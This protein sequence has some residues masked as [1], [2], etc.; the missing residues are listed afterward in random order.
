MFVYVMLSYDT[1]I[2]MKVVSARLALSAEAINSNRQKS[3]GF[4]LI[5]LLVVLSIVGLLSTII[6]VALQGARGK[7]KIASGQEFANNVYH[8]LGTSVVG[9]WNFDEGAGT[10]STDQSGNGNTA[11]G[12]PSGS[13]VTGLNGRAISLLSGQSVT[14]GATGAYS[15]PSFTIS[16]WIKNTSL[17]AGGFFNN[18]IM[19]I[20]NYNTCGFR[21]GL[22]ATGQPEITMGQSGG[23]FALTSS[24]PIGSDRFYNVVFTYNNSTQTGSFFVDGNAA[25]S[26]TGTYMPCGSGFV[27]SLNG[28]IGGTNS[29][30]SIFD[31]V[32]Y[33]NANFQ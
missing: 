11:T 6:L 31:E 17:N 18:I 24:V 12:I 29:S 9:M 5:E 13:W 28:G 8:L 19:G 30:N 32:R 2:T 33:Y 7:G 27:L 4:T 3:K 23:T 20:E 10:V 21:M 16:M 1:I 26:A 15:S 25:G 22:T 14:L